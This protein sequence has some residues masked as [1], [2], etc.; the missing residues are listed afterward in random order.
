MIKSEEKV[1]SE[2]ASYL[3]SFIDV[4]FILIIFFVLTMSEGMQALNVELPTVDSKASASLSKDYILLEIKKSSYLLNKKE[5]SSLDELKTATLTLLKK[6]P[7]YQ[8]II[9]VDKESTAQNFVELLAYFKQEKIKMA[10]ILTK[11]K[12]EK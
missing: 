6:N 4:L 8:F 11:K 9:A 2:E 3:T 10:K 7:K 1:I 5:I 12:E